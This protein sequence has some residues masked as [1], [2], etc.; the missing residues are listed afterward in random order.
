MIRSIVTMTATATPARYVA[1][2]KYHDRAGKAL[3]IASKYATILRGSVLDIGCDRA[4]LARH[5]PAG[6]TY[7]GAD[8]ND[9]A[10]LVINLDRDNLP[11]LDASIDT[12][13]AADVLEHLERLHAVFDELCRVARRRVIVSLPNPYRSFILAA[14]EGKASTLKY[15]GLPAD[16]PIDRHRWFFGARH[17]EAFIRERAARNGYEVEQLDVEEHG[18]PAWINSAGE[19]LFDDWEMRAGTTWAVLVRPSAT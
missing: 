1:P 13:I 15:Y 11:F 7:I 14:A 18:C 8:M 5:L 6:A 2:A 9:T 3:Y 17:A 12:V 16:K 4:Q 10:D 19:N